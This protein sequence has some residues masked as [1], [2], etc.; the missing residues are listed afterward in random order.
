M[1]IH[2]RISALETQVLPHQRGVIFVN[3]HIWAEDPKALTDAISDAAVKRF[4][5]DTG[6]DDDGKLFVVHWVEVGA[7]P[8]G[9][10]PTITGGYT[11]FSN[12]SPI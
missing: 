4:Q 3:D 11:V 7:R 12:S 5:E 9:M 8:E 6:F 2:D 1:R 10:L